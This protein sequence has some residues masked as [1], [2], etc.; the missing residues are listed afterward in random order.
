MSRPLRALALGILGGVGTASVLIGI[1]ALV[2]SIAAA[3]GA[4][5][6]EN[7]LPPVRVAALL[8]AGALA[9]VIAGAIAPRVRSR[10]GAALLGALVAIAAN[11]VI[12]VLDPRA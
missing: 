8:A 4:V 5:A 2:A 1:T 12:R 11:S 3:A 7:V 6:F 10:V 9:G